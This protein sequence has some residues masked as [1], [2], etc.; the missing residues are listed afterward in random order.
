MSTI[1]NWRVILGGIFLALI[2][3]LGL[4]VLTLAIK[5]EKTPQQ[6]Q[7]TAGLTIIPA[8]TPTL[9]VLP[10]TPGS[11]SATPGNGDSQGGIEIGV[12]VQISGTGG[13]GLRLRSGP[14]VKNAPL[15]L[16]MEAE[17]YQVKD[18]PKDADG[19]TWWYLEAPYDQNRKGWA[20]SKYLTIVASPPAQ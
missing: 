4:S 10:D 16:G 18:G 20:A 14:G 8:N 6:A 7:P 2:L 15:F 3:C 13:E 11:P 1:V 5:P 12:Y 19:Y 17:V 9:L